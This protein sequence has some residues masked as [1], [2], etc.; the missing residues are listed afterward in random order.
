MNSIKNKETHLEKNRQNVEKQLNAIKEK[1]SKYDK[2]LQKQVE[3][4]EVISSYSAEDAKKELIQLLRMR[5]K[6][7]PWLMSKKL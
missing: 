3:S 7:N 4:L 1:E 6:Q 5:P 2:L